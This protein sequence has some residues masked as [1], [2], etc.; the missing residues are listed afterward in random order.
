MAWT[1]QPKNLIILSALLLSGCATTGV[2]QDTVDSNRTLNEAAQRGDCAGATAALNALEEQGAATNTL[3]QGYLTTAH[4]CLVAEQYA[5]GKE[6]AEHYGMR[7]PSQPNQDYARYLALMAGFLQW[8]A[9]LERSDSEYSP[10]EIINGAREILGAVNRFRDTYSSSDYLEA[11]IPIANQLRSQ[12]ADAELSIAKRTRDDGN[13]TEASERA[14][15]IID[16]YPR[17][18]AA[19]DASAMLEAL[20]GS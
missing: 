11:L 20:S 13:F 15:Y 2:N 7:Y 10:G 12:I 5:I 3:A 9:S 4:A 17:T 16:Y 1:K 19:E 14:R 18:E 8:E 6:Q